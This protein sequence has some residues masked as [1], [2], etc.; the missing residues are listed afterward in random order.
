MK[1]IFYCFLVLFLLFPVATVF[2][3]GD[4]AG[5]MTDEISQCIESRKAE[6]DSK[7]EK[8]FIIGLNGEKIYLNIYRAYSA[9]NLLAIVPYRFYYWESEVREK[10]VVNP[11][12]K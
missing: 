9:K 11:A 6:M 4:P 7:P 3:G 5:G 1:K 2:S 12:G 10:E 8:D